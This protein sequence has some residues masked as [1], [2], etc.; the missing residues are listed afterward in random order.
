M[1]KEE[2]IRVIEY[3]SQHSI[4]Y[5]KDDLKNAECGTYLVQNHIMIKQIQ[6]A[7]EYV[8]ENLK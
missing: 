5:L 8:K 2:A 6:E 4:D 3:W 1:N 7:K